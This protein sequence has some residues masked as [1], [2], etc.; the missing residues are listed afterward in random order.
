MK[1]LITILLILIPCNTLAGDFFDKGEV[2]WL[3]QNIYHEA[4]G[5]DLYGQLMVGM[6]TLERL[7]SGKWGDTIKAVVTSPAQFSWYS[8]GKSDV[9]TNK[10]SWEASK[11]V[12]ML[13]M[14]LYTKIKDHG[15]MYYHNDT[16]D[17][18]WSKSMLKVL[19]IGNH[20]FYKERG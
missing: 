5:E 19:T 14:M 2:Y 7:H 20:V 17:P 1:I 8:D 9:P 4:R 15:V 3:T 11:G 10:D 16:V 6:V 18:Y 12:A 13:S